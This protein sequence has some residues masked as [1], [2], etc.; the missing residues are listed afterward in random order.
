MA[1]VKWLDA[2]Y[3]EATYDRSAVSMMEPMEVMSEGTLVWEDSEKVVLARDSFG[4][5]YRHFLIIPRV[6]VLSIT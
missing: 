2:H 3:E 1:K 6:C 5:S 4:D